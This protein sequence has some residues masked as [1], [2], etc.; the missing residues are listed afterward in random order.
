MEKVGMR[1]ETRSRRD[2][3]H[4]DRG[5]MDGRVYALLVDD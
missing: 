1:L 4:R 2:T 3:L 5:W